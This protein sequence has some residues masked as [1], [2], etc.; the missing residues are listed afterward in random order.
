MELKMIPDKLDNNFEAGEDQ[1]G[2]AEA[3]DLLTTSTKE[4]SIP[5]SIRLAVEQLVSSVAGKAQPNQL[6][7]IQ[8]P[9]T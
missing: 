6:M 5:E 8:L 4:H 3:I 7:K 2:L 1:Q 9:P